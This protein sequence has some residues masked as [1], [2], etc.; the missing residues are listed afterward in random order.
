MPFRRYTKRDQRASKPRRAG[1]RTRSVAKPTGS[2]VAKLQKQI[3]RLSR[4]VRK[5]PQKHV[6]TYRLTD[7]STERDYLAINL[8]NYT[9]GSS[10]VSTAT[11]F[12]TNPPAALTFGT[13]ADD[14]E[15]NRIYDASI[16]VQMKFSCR[17]ETDNI[18]YSVFLVSLK[19]QSN[20]GVMFDP[21]TGALDLT[22][23]VH[24]VQSPSSTGALGMVM[25]NKKCFNIHRKYFFTIGNNG[26]ALTQASAR[27]QVMSE[28]K[29][30]F[31]HKLGH[32]LTNPSGNVWQQMQTARDPS[33]QL[34][35][36]IFND[37]QFLD[38]QSQRFDMNMVRTVSVY[39]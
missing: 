9:T 20:D 33:K 23:N 12:T 25:L 36:L 8:S 34:Y 14:L 32:L 30:Y 10:T 15:T 21:V 7:R 3:D 19:D 38:L 11:G 37:D 6:L 2:N 17:N 31:R 1:V 5:V 16:G 22:P 29:F 26:A 13:T 35:L 28:R 18:N 24:Y 4:A 27:G 39:E